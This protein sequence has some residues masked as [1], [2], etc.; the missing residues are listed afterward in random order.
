MVLF[1][2]PAQPDDVGQG[3]ERCL[4]VDGAGIGHLYA[5]PARETDRLPLHQFRV[6]PGLS[7]DQQVVADLRQG[8]PG[9]RRRGRGRNGGQQA[10][11]STAPA[12]SIP[13]RA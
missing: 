5:G 3:G 6:V 12:V 4:R 9:R 10:C 8:D 13:A 2:V 1:N 7:G 11:A